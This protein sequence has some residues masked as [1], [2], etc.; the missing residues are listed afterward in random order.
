MEN[1]THAVPQNEANQE[2]RSRSR[3]RVA[4]MTRCS[5]E[6]PI[7]DSQCET[8]ASMDGQLQCA[9]AKIVELE[10]QV[11]GLQDDFD[12]AERFWIEEER[13]SNAAMC[14][15]E[16][17][18]ALRGVLKKMVGVRKVVAGSIAHLINGLDVQPLTDAEKKF[19]NDHGAFGQYCEWP[20][21]GREV[22][23]SLP[24]NS[25]ALRK[26]QVGVQCLLAAKKCPPTFSDEERSIAA[27]W[28]YWQTKGLR[29][30]EA[31]EDFDAGFLDVA[32][33]A[34]YGEYR[35]V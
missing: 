23:E 18:S 32:E 29:M 1:H 30:I 9:H 4:R 31:I 28:A 20:I 33:T 2:R 24:S 13:R 8:L 27:L 22:A 16:V 15:I 19:A 6:T 5:A 7:M 35:F 25:V 34:T 21:L 17:S 12:R 3:Q 26:I 14:L 11:K 10:E